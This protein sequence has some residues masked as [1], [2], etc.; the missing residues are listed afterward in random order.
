MNHIDCGFD[1]YNENAL[2]DVMRYI[3]ILMCTATMAG[4]AS[5]GSET[6]LWNKWFSHEKPSP[7]VKIV[8]QS[9]LPDVDFFKEPGL[10]DQYF[11]GK[12]TVGSWV[13]QKPGQLFQPVNIRHPSAAMVYFYRTDSHW[14]R[15]E[16]VAPNFFLNGER[17]PSLLNNHYYWIELPAGTYRFNISR[18]VAMAHFQEPKNIDF[19]VE[20]G[21][22]YYLRYE[23]QKFKG[24]P[25][26]NLALLKS[27]PLMQ[28][29]TEQG[30][31]EIRSTQLKTPGIS[32]V[33]YDDVQQVALDQNIH[34]LK[35]ES[36]SKKQLSEK[37]HPVLKKPFSLVDPRTW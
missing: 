34:G 27:G 24:S 30:R 1:K 35:Y 37:T 32:F 33:K 20:A 36:I 14:N 11:T 7:T 15:T 29:S 9:T 10:F 22:T 21:Q 18:P 12:F 25:D 26:P 6:S 2:R 13:N 4:C 31:E 8:N 23:E 28:V 17:I 16:I 5:T 3:M 19:S